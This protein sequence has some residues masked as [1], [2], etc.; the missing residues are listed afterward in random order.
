MSKHE[1][2]KAKIVFF[3]KS[4]NFKFT[5]IIGQGSFSTV[6]R[7]WNEDAEEGFAMKIVL[8]E[9]TAL[10]EREW[11]QLQHE[12]ILPLFDIEDCPEFELTWFLSPVVELTLDD[13]LKKPCLCE[14]YCMACELV[15]PWIKDIT[16]A[17][18][19]IHKKELSFLNLK[20][21]N[22]M[23]CKDE[24]VKIFGFH[25]LNKIGEFTTG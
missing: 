17:L 13:A 24:S 5:E 19:Y 20:L 3:R 6:L 12:N 15:V 21:S 9:D 23:I 16:S 7:V 11:R 2:R 25:R 14:K 10:K 22:V 18:N 1:Y 8:K 4:L